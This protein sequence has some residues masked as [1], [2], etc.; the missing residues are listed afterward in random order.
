[1]AL[2]AGILGIVAL[3]LLLATPFIYGLLMVL[4]GAVSESMLF[5]VLGIHVGAVALGGA[6]AVVLGMIA[7]VRLSRRRGAWV[8]HGWAITGLCTGP[9]PLLLGGL[10]TLIAVGQLTSQSTPPVVDATMVNSPAGCAPYG[11]P[12]PYSSSPSYCLPPALPSASPMST[13]PAPATAVPWTPAAPAAPATKYDA[14]EA[15]PATAAEPSTETKPA[16]I[17]ETPKE[18]DSKPR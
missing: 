6:L 15:K 8:G 12:A 17:A 4:D 1:M 5:A 9:M 3:V 7:L 14:V 16:V 11:S 2:S 18:D 13:L 10:V